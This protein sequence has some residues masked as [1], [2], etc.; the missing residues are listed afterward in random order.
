M[1][2]QSF[3]TFEAEAMAAGFDEVIERTWESGLALDMHS[4]QFDVESVVVRGEMWLTC[5][6]NTRH[7][8]PG[9][10][11][12]LAADEPH[13]ERY[14]PQGATTWIARRHVAGAGR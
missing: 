10:G 1:D 3:E 2:A 7:L 8:M 5:D 4:H 12:A 13:S 6:G 14:G 11:F 9:Q